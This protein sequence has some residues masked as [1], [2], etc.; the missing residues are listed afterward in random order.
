M[1]RHGELLTEGGVYGPSGFHYKPDQMARFISFCDDFTIKPVVRGAINLP[2]GT[3]P[4]IYSQD[5][6][7]VLVNANLRYPSKVEKISTEMEKYG[8]K[9]LP[10]HS[11]QLYEYPGIKRAELP[12]NWGVF[13]FKGKYYDAS[14]SFKMLS[15]DG[16]SLAFFV[17]N[18]SSKSSELFYLQY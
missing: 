3:N 11:Y 16:H 4:L 6:R 7:F 12:Q 5:G 13:R 1:D 14:E 8:N 18:C 15:P 10:Y 2:E 9:H 17:R